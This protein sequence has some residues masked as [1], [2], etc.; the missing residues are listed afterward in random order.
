MP[1]GKALLGQV[2]TVALVLAVV[3]AFVALTK[4]VVRPLLPD[5]LGWFGAP[6]SWVIVMAGFGVIAWAI[7][8]I[9]AWGGKDD[10]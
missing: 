9:R 1:S 5:W 3:V 2:V 7:A 6:V 4:F 8:W 10:A